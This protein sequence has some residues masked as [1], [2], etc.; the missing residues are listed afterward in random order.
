MIIECKYTDYTESPIFSLIVFD[1]GLS[2][3]DR[4]YCHRVGYKTHTRYDTH[5]VGAWRVT[6]KNE[7]I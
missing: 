3:K 2:I 7:F 4:L 5:I 1:T 6:Y